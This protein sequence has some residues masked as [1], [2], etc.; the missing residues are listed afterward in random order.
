[1]TELPKTSRPAAGAL[2]EAG[3]ASLEDL[4]RRTEQ[5]VLELHGMGPKAFGL[6][7]AA[8]AEKGLSFAKG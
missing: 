7:K 8:M 2:A 6:L 4:A 5:E 1:M 3:I